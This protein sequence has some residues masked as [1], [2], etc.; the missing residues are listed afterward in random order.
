[1]TINLTDKLQEAAGQRHDGLRP[2]ERRRTDLADSYASSSR[3]RGNRPQEKS[4]PGALPP[5]IA[6]LLSF[7][8][9]AAL[10]QYAA[11]LARRQG[12]SADAA[13]LAEGL[14]SEDS[15]YGPSLTTS[16]SIFSMKVCG[17]SRPPIR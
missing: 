6:F 12:V 10:L 17:L 15:F 7:G 3:S 8:V 4:T 1:M 13:L 5:E 11:T 14:V 9:P 16:A 2:I